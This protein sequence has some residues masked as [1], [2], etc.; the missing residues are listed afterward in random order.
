MQWY[1]YPPLPPSLLQHQP[2]PPPHPAAVHVIL[3]RATTQATCE[4]KVVS[5]C[6]ACPVA[7]EAF[8][9]RQYLDSGLKTAG[10]IFAMAVNICCTPVR[11]SLKV[12]QET[13]LQVGQCSKVT[14]EP[15][16]TYWVV[17][18]SFSFFLI[19]VK[20]LCYFSLCN[21]LL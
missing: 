15:N 7:A 3:T 14:T 19:I 16:G 9:M 4:Q 21:P 8:V 12:H 20:P 17:S 1:L 6:Y 18:R 5:T 2:Q 11:L 10:N 13:Q